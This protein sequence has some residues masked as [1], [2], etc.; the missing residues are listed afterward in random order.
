MTIDKAIK[1]LNSLERTLAPTTAASGTDAI[2]LGIEALRFIDYNRSGS[3]N[4]PFNLLPGETE[5]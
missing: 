5:E 4:P 1:I 3:Y 2:K